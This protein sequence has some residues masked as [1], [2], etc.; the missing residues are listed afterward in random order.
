MQFLSFC[1]RFSVSRTHILLLQLGD[2]IS[3]SAR[4]LSVFDE[5][6]K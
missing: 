5:V 4:A 3:F 1:I 6:M 2:L